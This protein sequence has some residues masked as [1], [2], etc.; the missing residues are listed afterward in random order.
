MGKIVRRGI[1]FSGGGGSSISNP[2]A[3][4]VTF[5]NTDTGLEATNVQDAVTEVN[6]K[7][8]NLIKN[9]TITTNTFAVVSGIP[10]SK[11]I[12]SCLCTYT[13]IALMAFP[14]N[15]GGKFWSVDVRKANDLSLND[16]STTITVTYL[17][18]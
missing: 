16:I 11:P 10:L 7:L 14:T 17:D 13:N 12:V 6:S 8:S 5:D 2:T 3:A 4:S 18:I 9:K 1:D 15:R